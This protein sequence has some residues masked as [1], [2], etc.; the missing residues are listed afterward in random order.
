[1][2][3]RKP[4][5][6]PSPSSPSELAQRSPDDEETIQISITAEMAREKSKQGQRRV[7][8]QRWQ[9][10][11]DMLE[12]V[13]NEVHEEIIKAAA[14]GKR[15][16]LY[17]VPLPGYPQAED[18][19]EEAVGRLSSALIMVGYTVTQERPTYLGVGKE[20]LVLKIDWQ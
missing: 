17:Q 12:R 1:M 18:I 15:R 11:R 19:R 20:Q 3:R 2:K 13:R 8:S 9:R 7:D 10:L 16:I 4:N 6:L 14:D 5:L